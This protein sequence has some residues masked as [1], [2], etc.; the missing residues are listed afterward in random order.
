MPSL[1][2]T[3][4][5]ISYL[6]QFLLAWVITTYLGQRFFA[7]KAPNPSSQDRLLAV[8]FVSVTVFS[9][10]LFL[11][12]SLLPAERLP[13]VFIETF[14]LGLMLVALIQLAYQFPSPRENQKL[15]RR[16]ALILTS[17]YALW[18]ASFAIWR[19][20]R[21]QQGEVEFRPA[22][23][24]YPP[25]FEFLW[26]VFVFGRG[27]WQNWNQLASCR[28]A[29]IF[30]IPF[31]LATINYLRSFGLIPTP[32]YHISLSVGI[33]ATLFMFALNYLAS[34]AETTS[35]MAKFSGAIL[36]SVLAV[37]GVIAW[38]VTPAYAAKYTPN[39]LDQRT[40][41]FSPNI[42]GGYAV[43]EAPF[44]FESNFGQNL[45]LTD[46]NNKQ[47][48]A[49][50]TGFEFAFY[51]KRYV[52]LFISN[53][54]V[55]SFGEA[56]D[57][58][59]LE[60]NFSSLPV[61][62]ALALDLNPESSINGGVFLR[63]EAEKLV[64]TYSRLKNFNYPENEYTFQVVLHSSGSFE[65]T[66]NG[67]P[68]NQQYYAN[69]RS[70]AAIWA[71]GAK[72]AGTAFWRA[73]N[74]SLP[75]QGGPEGIVKDEHRAFR[76][77]LHEFL[78]P[79]AGA[80]LASSLLFLAGLPL[81]LN[82][83]VSRPLNSLFKGVE[84]L[85]RGQLTHRIPVYFNDEVGYLTQS[86]NHLASELDSLVKNLESRVTERTADLLAANE[87]LR[88]LSSAI[89]QSPSS[90]LITDLDANIEYVNPAFTH[91]TGYTFEEVRGRDPG[92]LKSEL[93]TAQTYEEMWKALLA[94]KTWRGE[95]ANRKKNGSLY[96][97]SLVIAPVHDEQG[98]VTHYVSIHEDITTKKL[99][100][101]SLLESEKQYRDLFEM[102]SDA[103]LIIRNADGLI[104][105]ANSAAT[106]LYG[107]SHEELL[108]RHNFDLS[109]EPEATQK[110]TNSPAPTDQIVSIPL[111]WH[112]K[113]GGTVFPVEI[114]A[115][116]ISWK[117]ESVHLAA[118]RDV[119]KRQQIEA[120]LER[121][122][123]TDPLTG[124]F[125][126]RHFFAEAEKVFARSNF[127]PYELAVLMIDVDHFKMVN[128]TYGHQQGDLV[129]REIA[130]RIQESLRP[131]DILGRYGGEE[132]VA[133]L[134][135]TSSREL[136]PIADRILK[137]IQETS[138]DG[139]G[140]RIS[141][142]IS[143]GLARLTEKV[144]TLDELLSRADQALYT[145]KQL[146]RNRWAAWEA[147]QDKPE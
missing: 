37:L 90:I 110:A 66:Y 88:K 21:L 120:E 145:A 56:L 55:I 99:A 30:S 11:D 91:S 146:G 49:A 70:A 18:E 73:D 13:V 74:L 104:L 87:Q 132:F 82:Y 105:E 126:R 97:E 65:L 36:T 10:T 119:T 52:N 136:G 24:D 93:T 42:Q 38:L 76:K 61:I 94:G 33:L 17:L 122:A 23:M 113:K 138:F 51:G 121:L 59:D 100:E 108:A 127:A 32:F 142:T 118:I 130:Q 107:F 67:L 19:F 31:L 102:E 89:E 7:S 106:A 50:V 123:I 8:F 116:F 96:W 6:N 131:T 63:R 16:I 45:E 14:V 47:P 41:L 112:R 139:N 9:F 4:A 5:S 129:L 53:D 25:I 44:V 80:V 48:H 84:Q 68:R 124:L 135:R 28:F 140:T 75:L 29:L 62:L 101:Q 39:V 125:N 111:R 86:F 54:G 117:G 12:A 83:G 57:Y 144:A 35:L 109:A 69:D 26:V 34:R 64:I 137:S 115:R 128:D 141:V 58:K 43:S 72:P 114:T 60:N 20:Y 22:Y 40:L 95:L 133:L 103:L 92:L 85:N 71:I 79:L 143:L 2:L 78:W 98:A 27:T 134:P 1:Y 81:S 77:Y 15:E 46:A 3:P 147:S